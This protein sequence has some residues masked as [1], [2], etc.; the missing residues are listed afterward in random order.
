M[1]L[2]DT[3]EVEEIGLEV[4]WMRCR[5]CGRSW[6]V[7]KDN[8]QGSWRCP[9]EPH[10]GF[11]QGGDVPMSPPTHRPRSHPTLGPELMASLP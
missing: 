11:G 8:F 2:V 7:F 6:E 4:T 3:Y 10:D 5:R 9:G 1:S